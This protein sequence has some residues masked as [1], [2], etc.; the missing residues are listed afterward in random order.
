MSATAPPGRDLRAILAERGFRRLLVARLTSQVA[1]GWFQAALAGSLL[2]NPERQASPL[3]I[4][5]G[6]AILLLPYSVL[7]PFVGVFLDRWQRRTA[8]YVAN[9]VRAGLV[10]PAAIM[11][12]RGHEDALFAIFALL[13]IAANRFFL[14]GLGASLPHVVQDPRLVTANA[15]ATTLG[16]VAY[17]MGL[18]TAAAVLGTPLVG[19]D[20]RGYAAIALLGAAGYVTSA[21]LLRALFTRTA[22]GPDESERRT[23]LL[24]AA[25][26]DVAR[27][28]VH[29]LRHLVQRRAAGY[30]L[31]VQAGHRGLYG[32]LA[33]ATLLLFSRYFTGGDDGRSISGLGLVIASGGL[34]ALVAAFVTPVATRRLPGWAW[35]SVL[36]GGT[37]VV[38]VVLIPPFRAPLVLISTFLLNIASQGTKIVV[39]TALQHECDDAYRGRVFSLNDTAFNATFVGGLFVGATLLPSNGRSGPAVVVIALAYGLLATWYAVVGRRAAQPR[40]AVAQ[41]SRTISTR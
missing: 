18:G 7:G 24:L 31:L 32:V 29:G 30:A 40:T 22:L 34:G 16:T 17:A 6:F 1:D 3:A 38:L 12:S 2:F 20:N 8:L 11:L 15:A 5:T 13:V 4:A 37:G 39:D 14:A 27:G 9:L 36:L 19:I 35:I 41:E 28:M 10:V 21:L 26:V 25:V 33:L 23:D